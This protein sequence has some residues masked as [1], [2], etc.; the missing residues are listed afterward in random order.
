MNKK[1]AETLKNK[2]IALLL[3][4]GFVARTFGYAEKE[5]HVIIIMQEGCIQSIK[6]TNPA[7]KVS[8]AIEPDEFTDNDDPTEYDR[9]TAL[10]ATDEYTE[11]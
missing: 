9:L 7:V 11:I 10:A 3:E 1:E 2:V 6:S 4:N 5:I 8:V